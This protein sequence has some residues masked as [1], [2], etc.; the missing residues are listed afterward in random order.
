[1]P[2]QTPEV[3]IVGSAAELIQ[4]YK[5]DGTDNIVAANFGPSVRPPY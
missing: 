4:S 1:M 2:Y 3:K 5:P